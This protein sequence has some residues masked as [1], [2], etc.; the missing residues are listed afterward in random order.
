MAPS[1]LHGIGDC[2]A[3][4]HQVD[5]R[6]RGAQLAAAVDGR[7]GA[8]QLHWVYLTCERAIM[9]SLVIFVPT[10]VLFRQEPWTSIESCVQHDSCGHFN[11]VPTILAVRV[12][13]ARRD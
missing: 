10:A 5:H 8:C 13:P 4:L 2:S 12:E 3:A 11:G 7:T 1:S 6:P 9:S